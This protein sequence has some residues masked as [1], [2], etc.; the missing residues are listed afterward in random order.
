MGGSQNKDALCQGEVERFVG[1]SCTGARVRVA[2]MP[3]GRQQLASMELQCRFLEVEM[4]VRSNDD[5]S[6]GNGQ[7]FAIYTCGHV[8]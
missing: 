2:G 6:L 8:V 4:S 1:P 7:F 3:R 5:S